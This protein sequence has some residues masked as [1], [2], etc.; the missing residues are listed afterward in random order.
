MTKQ[1]KENFIKGFQK[2][3]LSGICKEI[4]VSREN[5]YTGKASEETIEKV[6]NKLLDELNKII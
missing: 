1:E 2:I 6:Y 3:K 5:I 4:G